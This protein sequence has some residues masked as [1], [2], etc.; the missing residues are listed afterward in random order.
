MY[1]KGQKTINQVY[2]EVRARIGEGGL[3]LRVAVDH[4][5]RRHRH[6]SPTPARLRLSPPVTTTGCHPVPESPGPTG[7]VHVLPS[8]QHAASWG[9]L[10]RSGARGSP[11]S[12]FVPCTCLTRVPAAGT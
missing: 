9:G 12:N 11:T 3:L 7:G 6:V 10:H 5:R 8:G 1:R 2:E 4:S